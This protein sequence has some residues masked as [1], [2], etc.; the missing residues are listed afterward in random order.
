MSEYNCPF[1]ESEV[2]EQ[3]ALYGGR[4]PTCFGDIP[5]EEAATDPGEAVKQQ[6]AADDARRAKMKVY[7]PVLFALPVL[8]TIVGFTGWTLLS[9]G[10]ST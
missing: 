5:G 4:C 10:A 3:L 8:V 1:C 9:A 2:S 7:A 6:E